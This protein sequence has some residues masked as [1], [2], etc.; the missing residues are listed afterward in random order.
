MLLRWIIRSFWPRVWA[1]ANKWLEDDGPTWA[2]SLGYYAVFSF[3]PVILVLLSG[4]GF[5][6]KFSPQPE[7]QPKQLVKLIGQQ[8]SPQLAEQITKLLNSV[9]SGVQSKASGGGAI[10][11]AV[12]VFAA[13]GVFTQLEAAFGRIWNIYADPNRKTG[14]WAAVKNALFVRLRAF[15]M[16]LATGALVLLAF[17]ATTVVTAIVHRFDQML[18]G[19]GPM[20]LRVASIVVGGVLNT[21]CFALLYRF[22]PKRRVLWRHALGGAVVTGIAWEIGRQLLALFLASGSYSAYGI[23]GSLIVL[24]L[25]CYYGSIVLLFG[26]EFVEIN[27]RM[28]ETRRAAATAAPTRA[29]MK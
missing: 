23:I 24:M 29:E 10:G 12:L 17:I 21:L 5:V 15:L 19:L 28:Y 13:I 18:F 9:L 11:L 27:G 22:L 7:L 20:L 4:V 3:F 25:W 14:L 26:A 8:T 16:L 6:L 1:A 2:A